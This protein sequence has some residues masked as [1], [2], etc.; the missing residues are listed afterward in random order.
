MESEAVKIYNQGFRYVK[1][2]MPSDAVDF[3][4]YV[5]EKIQLANLRA[6]SNRGGYIKR[7]I[8]ENWTDDRLAKQQQAK[9]RQEI[10]NKI[11]AMEQ[12]KEEMVKQRGEEMQAICKKMIE[13][14]VSLAEDFFSNALKSKKSDY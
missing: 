11:A 7:A 5:R 13:E 10:R 4:D 2:D 9:A 1:H 8:E 3:E 14:N 6:K 12:Q